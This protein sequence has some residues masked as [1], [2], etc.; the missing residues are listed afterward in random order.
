MLTAVAPGI[1]GGASFS[2]DGLFRMHLWRAWSD[3]ARLLFVMLNPS[4]AGAKFDDPTIRRCMG[5]GRTLGFGGIEVVNL[6]AWRATDPRQLRANK[7]PVGEEN[8]SW[9]EGAVRDAVERG[10]DIC[11][12]WGN[13]AHGMA[14]TREV[15]QLIRG[16]GGAPKCLG[17][18][19]L[20]EPMHPLFVPASRRLQPF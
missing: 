11:V 20:G 18:T 4:T 13:M 14:R 19:A 10:G 17:R 12:A 3:D 2:T 8:D 16:A 6:F 9:I 1:G 5:F 7:Y 15:L